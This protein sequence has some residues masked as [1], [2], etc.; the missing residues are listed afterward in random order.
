MDI[1]EDDR[2]AIAEMAKRSFV[3]ECIILEA[4]ESMGHTPK[5]YGSKELLQDNTWPFPGGYLYVLAMSKV[6]GRAVTDIPD[7]PD[8]T[9]H[10]LSRICEQLA[11]TL[12][13]VLSMLNYLLPPW[14]L[15]TELK[16]CLILIAL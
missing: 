3:E 14:R 13:Y 5:Y 2:P 11:N 6:P 8:L 12:E 7:I 15:S 1:F 16:A 4:C 9:E 10:E